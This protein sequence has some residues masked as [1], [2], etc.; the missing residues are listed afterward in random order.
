LDDDNLS[1]VVVAGKTDQPDYC[2]LDELPQRAAKRMAEHLFPVGIKRISSLLLYSRGGDS[3]SMACE[4]IRGMKPWL[5]FFVIWK[6]FL[7]TRGWHSSVDQEGYRVAIEQGK[8]I[9]ALETIE[10]QI[11]VLET[12]SREKI[13]AFIENADSWDRYAKQFFRSYLVADLNTM[14][15]IAKKFPSRHPSVIDD[16]DYIFFQRMSHDLQRGKVVAFLGAPH[17][18]GVLRL[19]LEHGFK[20]SGPEAGA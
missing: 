13:I 20:V 4:M 7:E 8:D 12:L 16:R 14:R 11:Q 15:R 3:H 10:E 9:I 18:P 17:V 19:L 5:A 6:K 1:K 2:L